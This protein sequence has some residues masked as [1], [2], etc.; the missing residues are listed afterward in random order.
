MAKRV[1]GASVALLLALCLGAAAQA[2]SL[3][4]TETELVQAVND[5]RTAKRLPPLEVDLRLVRAARAHTT[6]LLRGDVLAHWGLGSRLDS[7]QARG[8]LFG[9]NL[10]WGEGSHAVPRALVQAW[11]ASPAHRANLLHPGFSRIGIGA[12]VGAFAGSSAA[13]V[14]TAAFAGQ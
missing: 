7:F 5:A 13:T 8:R 14:V 6:A 10:G 9:E 11:L 4:T 3:S 2:A 1:Y 12:R